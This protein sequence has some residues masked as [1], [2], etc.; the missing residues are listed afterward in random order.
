MTG[1]VKMAEKG[2]GIRKQEI[3]TARGIGEGTRS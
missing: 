1:N 3:G 2:T